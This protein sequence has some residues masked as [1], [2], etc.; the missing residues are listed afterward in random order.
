MIPTDRVRFRELVKQ[1]S[2]GRPVAYLVG[3]REF[4]SME[5]EVDPRVLIPRPETE[6]LASRALA[7][8]PKDRPSRF[9]DIGTGSGAIAIVLASHRPSATGVAIDISPD[10][11]N[12]AQ[13]NVARHHLSDRIELRTGGMLA[14]LARDEHFDVI[15]S[16]PP[17][18][19]ESEYASLPKDVRDFEPRQ[20]LVAGA[21]GLFVLAD[22]VE[23]APE[24]LLPGGSLLLEFGIDHAQPMKDRVLADPRYL[25]CEI[26]AD[27]TRTPRVLVAKTRPSP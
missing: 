14:T 26:V 21:D 4:F 18:V 17:Y 5:F 10:A 6:V 24:Y 23:H 2:Q 7:Y 22:I 12:V 20:A 11:L 3:K 8:L 16:N 27:D 15:A 13:Q 9:L 19:R 1:R 25:S